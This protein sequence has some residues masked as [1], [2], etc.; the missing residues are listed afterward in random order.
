MM[1]KIVIILLCGLIPSSGFAETPDWTEPRP[2]TYQYQTSITC[3]IFVNGVEST[4]PDN[5]IAVFVGE[6]IRGVD[7]EFET[8]PTGFLARFPIYSDRASGE[9]M[10]LKFYDGERDQ[11]YDIESTITFE[12]EPIGSIGD[13]FRFDIEIEELVAD[14]AI[15]QAS[16]TV[17]LTVQFRDQ[18]TGTITSWSWD[19]DND[20]IEDSD[21]QNPEHSYNEM[22]IYTVKLTI[23]DGVL[24]D[25]EIKI[26]CITACSRYDVNK[27]GVID[28]LDVQLI[29]DHW[30]D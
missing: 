23:S 5:Q 4:N 1:R 18:S 14:F 13:P 15:D 11:L 20:G 17:P 7:Q 22:G 26:D 30:G 19:F 12:N 8:F 10:S 21:D 27:D 2:G 25:D 24:S 9:E 16:G 6:E 29:I 28:I 3:H